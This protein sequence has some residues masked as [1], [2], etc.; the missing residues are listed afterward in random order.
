MKCCPH[1]HRHFSWSKPLSALLAALCLLSLPNTTAAATYKSP[2]VQ[3][4][5]I[6]AS[7]LTWP[8]EKRAEVAEKIA[9]WLRGKAPATQEAMDS[10][11]KAVALA[12]ILNSTDR[13]AV[14]ANARLKSG[15]PVPS[16]PGMTNEGLAKYLLK[17]AEDLLK[18]IA[19]ENPRLAGLFLLFAAD[20]APDDDDVIY[21]NAVHA[22]K[23]NKVSWDAIMG[24][25]PATASTA[26]AT[27]QPG[28][29][30]LGASASVNPAYANTTKP[31]ELK[32]ASIKG[33]FVMQTAGQ[34]V[35]EALDIIGTVGGH[36]QRDIVKTRFARPVGK[37]MLTSYREALRAIA[38]R[39]PHRQGGSELTFSFG[40]K[41]TKKDGGSAGL[42]FFALCWSLLEG[43]AIDQ[44][45]AVTGDLTVDWKVRPIGGVPE[46]IQ[47][48]MR[49]KCSYVVL[50]EANRMQVVDGVLLNSAQM[51]WKI[52][53]VSAGNLAEAVAMIRTDRSPEHSAAI[54]KFAE[55][56][57][58][59][60]A[61]GMAGL[62]DPAIKPALEQVVT[63]MPNH[64]SAQ[65][66]MDGIGGKFPRKLTLEG[67]LDEILMSVAPAI[68]LFGINE[69]NHVQYALETS[70][71]ALAINKQRLQKLR[72]I[73][74]PESAPFYRA[75]TTLLAAFEDF[76]SA[77]EAVA[78]AKGGSASLFIRKQ[79]QAIAKK[80]EAMDGWDGVVQRMQVD[81]GFMEALMRK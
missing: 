78:K 50:P 59:L 40:D 53:I 52:Q 56:Q 9:S 28:K 61:K 69:R 6:A 65:L 8:K 49:D 36:H 67:S 3:D 12:L 20:L 71:N 5:G 35:G 25:K 58:I 55:V 33:L 21:Q 75:S 81:K 30:V 19:Q 32:Q 60:N 48:A 13:T 1:T 29:G 64:L 4:S 38:I 68:P 34:T 18:P 77:S 57:G 62:R 51:L 39:Y 10:C 66:L 80:K 37:E 17:E 23:Y 41:Y 2:A 79:A 26:T 31:Y 11:T 16:S 15:K 42:A 76:R 7:R 46:K 72:P 27:G 44:S 74:H 47:G 22:E 24:K 63:K 54:A 14:I 70:G 73:A 45:V 43:V